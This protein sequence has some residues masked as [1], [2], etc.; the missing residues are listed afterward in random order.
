MRPLALSPARCARLAIALC[1]GCLGAVLPAQA[2]DLTSKGVTIEAPAQGTIARPGSTV[3]IKV[4]LDPS[5]KASQVSLLVGTWDE[6]VSI[7]DDAPPYDLPLQID[8]RWSGPLRVMF[9]VLGKREKLIGSGELVINVVPSDLPVAIAVTDPVQMVASSSSNKPKE[10]INVR[11][12]YANGIVRDVARLDLG[13]SFHSSDPQVVAVDGEG[14]LTARA[15]G[16]AVVTVKNG[17]LSKEVPVDVRPNPK[18]RM[19]SVAVTSQVA[20][21]IAAK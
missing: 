5:L 21:G 10:H 6:L 20:S 7:A 19:P 17:D 1:A 3:T 4:R 2:K 13:T 12:T 14:Y 9:S 16:R 18:Q 11:G 15:P 8:P